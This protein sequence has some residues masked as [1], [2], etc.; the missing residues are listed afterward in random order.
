MPGQLLI[1]LHVTYI[2][3]TGTICSCTPQ[4]VTTD[5][6]IKAVLHWVEYSAVTES[7]GTVIQISTIKSVAEKAQG[8]EYIS[9]IF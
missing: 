3:I 1:S 9:A 7:R 8:I 4:E 2:A 6:S 5:S